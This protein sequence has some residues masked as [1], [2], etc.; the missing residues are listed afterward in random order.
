V[1]ELLNIS[2]QKLKKKIYCEEENIDFR[3]LLILYNVSAIVLDYVSLSENVKVIYMPL[4]TPVM[5][6]IDQ[7]V[8]SALKLYYL[9]HILISSLV[10]NG[11]RSCIMGCWETIPC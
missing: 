7:S 10:K 3:I 5:Q 11:S 6:P 1:I 9:H 8:I 2:C 4:R